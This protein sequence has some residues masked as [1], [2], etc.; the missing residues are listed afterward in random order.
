VGKKTNA[1]QRLELVGQVAEQTCFSLLTQNGSLD[2]QANS[3]LE[4]D[5]LVSCFS[6]ILDDVHAED[7]RALYEGSPETSLAN[8]TVNHNGLGTEVPYHP[9]DLMEEI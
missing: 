1:L 8:S 9:S 7:W 5:A 4:R 3:K 6:M 2:L